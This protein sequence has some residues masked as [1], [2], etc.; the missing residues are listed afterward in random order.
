MGTQLP[1]PK[2]G[3]SL[4][5]FSAHVY[6]NQTAKWIKMPLG[7]KAGHIVLDEDPS[8]PPRPKRDTAYQ[9]SAHIFCGQRAGWI[10]MPLGKKVGLVPGHIMLHGD[11]APPKRVQPPPQYSA[12][13]IVAKQSPISATVEHVSKWNPAYRTLEF[14]SRCDHTCKFRWLCNNVGLGEHVTCHLFWLL[15]VHSLLYSSARAKPTPV[16]RFWRSICRA[17]CYRI[18]R[19]LLGLAVRLLSTMGPNLQSLQFQGVT[20]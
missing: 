1:F 13:S 7:M 15:S 20:R 2:R 16:N 9:F 8:A 19:H 3:H 4:P 5:R 11:P 18:K 6:C 10:K 12:I 17:T 14:I